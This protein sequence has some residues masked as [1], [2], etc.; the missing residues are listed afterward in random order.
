MLI[1]EFVNLG[2]IRGIGSMPARKCLQL[3]ENRLSAFELSLKDDIVCL[4]TDG[5]SVMTVLGGEAALY[6]QQCPADGVQLAILDVLYKKKRKLLNLNN[7]NLK[8]T[9]IL[10]SLT[11]MMIMTTVVFMLQLRS[12]KIM[13]LFSKI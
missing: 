12:M 11:V 6:H 3:L 5:A 10:M 7:I 4:T 13:N 1:N 8:K 9:T 2:L